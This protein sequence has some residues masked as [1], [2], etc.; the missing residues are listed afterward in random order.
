MT[1]QESCTLRKSLLANHAAWYAS[2]NWARLASG[3]QLAAI[4]A[5][6]LVLIDRLQSGISRATSRAA[7]KSWLASSPARYELH[8]NRSRA[9]NQRS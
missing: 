7:R 3:G 5:N 9:K 8:H 4:P 1:R 2:F 6:A